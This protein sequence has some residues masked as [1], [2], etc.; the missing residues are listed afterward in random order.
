MSNIFCMVSLL[1][2]SA[3]QVLFDFVITFHFFFGQSRFMS[4]HLFFPFHCFVIVCRYLLSKML[5]KPSLGILI[6]KSQTKDVNKY[7]PCFPL[8][9]VDTSQFLQRFDCF[10][11]IIPDV[12]RWD[13]ASSSDSAVAFVKF[14]KEKSERSWAE[15]NVVSTL[16]LF[17]ASVPRPLGKG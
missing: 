12:L 4:R 14:F 8:D 16:G 11:G 10:S 13:A 6:F 9:I 17:E 3:T 2:S 7:V 1:I 15:S 5:F